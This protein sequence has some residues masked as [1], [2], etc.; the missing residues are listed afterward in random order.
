MD[1][2]IWKGEFRQNFKTM[3][4]IL[5]QKQNG[6]NFSRVNSGPR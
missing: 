3:D 6:Q 2:Y 1:Q 5:C 4:D